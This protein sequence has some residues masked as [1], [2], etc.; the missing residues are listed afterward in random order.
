MIKVLIAEDSLVMQQVL[1]RAIS[2]DPLLTVVGVASDGEEALKAVRE[3]HPDVI[4]M[5]WQMPTFDGLEAT[6]IIME[7]TPTPIVIVT[8]SVAAND[9]AASFR[10]IEAGALAILHQPPSVDHPD[11][12]REILQLTRTLKLM[13]EVK[14]V[15]RTARSSTVQ[16]K[17]RLSGEKFFRPESDIQIVAIGAS[18]GGPNVLQK[19]L[20]GL[21]KDLPVPLFIVQHISKGFTAGFVEWL[22][23]TTKFP[24]RVAAHGEYALRGH[25][26]VAPDDF[27]MGVERGPNIVLNHNDEENGLRP[28]VA[29]LFRSVSHNFGPNAAGVLLTG[30]GRDGADELKIMKDQGAVTFA[31]DKES[32]IIHGMP[33]EAIKLNAATYVLSPEEI[34]VALTALIKKNESVIV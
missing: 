2:S 23:N 15:K 1:K 5:G 28:S 12:E 7:T 33:G 29:H 4:A 18:T 27:H 24:L 34:A 17:A 8:G 21:P 6:R 14:L 25:G 22:Q 3:F 9:A 19:I 30:M 16:E 26:Y 32:S 11:Y 13:S 20:S 31:Q 10:M